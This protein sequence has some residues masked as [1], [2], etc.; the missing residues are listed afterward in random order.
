[1]EDIPLYIGKR[2]N[3]IVISGGG[4]KGFTALGALTRLIELEIIVNP[5]IYCVVPL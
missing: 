3:I 2:K 4:L 5:D 1:M